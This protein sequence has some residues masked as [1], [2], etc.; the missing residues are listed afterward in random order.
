LARI[1]PPG[2]TSWAW[3]STVADE[4]SVIHG[5]TLSAE[6]A[7]LGTATL[8]G[9]DDAQKDYGAKCTEKLTLWNGKYPLE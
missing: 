1:H 8:I 4:T 9:P 7:V 2:P 3:Q 5:N 6:A